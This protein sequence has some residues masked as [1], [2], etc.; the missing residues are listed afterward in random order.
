VNYSSSAA[1][2]VAVGAVIVV[3]VV[4][5]S[6]FGTNDCMSVNFGR[7]SSLKCTTKKIFKLAFTS[8]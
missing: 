4:V 3:V 5:I 7:T 8:N 6:P 1:A 2:A